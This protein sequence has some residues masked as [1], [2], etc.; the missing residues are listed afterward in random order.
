M[1]ISA[2]DVMRLRETTGIGMMKCKQALFDADGDFEKAIDVLRKQGLATADRRAGRATS[3]GRIGCYI[4]HNGKVGS[5]VEVRCESDFVASN[6]EFI[7]FADGLCMHVVA[8]KPIAVRREEVPAEIVDKE[9]EIYSEQVK[10]KPEQVISKIVEGKLGKF[11][12]ERCLLEQPY[13]KDDSQTVEEV[14]KGLI[15]K[16]GENMSIERFTRFEI[17]ENERE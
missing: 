11:F 12:Q 13:V 16:F 6:E 3:Q 10:D 8:I 4:H 14:L 5:M 2:K 9:R 17:G 7:S 1:A 15:S